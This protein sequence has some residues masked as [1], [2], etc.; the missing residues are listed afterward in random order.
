MERI[1]N[2]ELIDYLLE[3]GLISKCQHGFLRKHS[4]STNLLESVNDWSINLH[5]NMTTDDVFIDFKKAFDSVSYPK[6][7]S[8]LVSYGICGDLLAWL[9]AF[10]SNRT[11]AVKILNCLSKTSLSL[12]GCPKVVFWARP[13]FCCTLTTLLT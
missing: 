7:I 4:T 8:K 3:H 9:N 2:L 5:N 13:C 6:L 10:L 11:Q 12:A 1:I